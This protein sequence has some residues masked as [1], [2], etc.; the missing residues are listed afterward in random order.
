M[1]IRVFIVDDSAVARLSM[2]RTLR[3]DPDLLLVGEATTGTEAL[4]A[5]PG[6][7]PDIVLMDVMMPEL[8]GLETTA[9]LMQRSARPILIVSDLVGVDS[10]LN[11]RALEAGALDLVRKPTAAEVDDPQRAR[12]WL[13]RLK[14][15]AGVPV[16]TRRSPG[17]R[18]AVP[19]VESRPPQ[20]GELPSL[21]AI[22]ASTGGPPAL[23]EI[24][25]ALG[26]ARPWPM[27]IVQHIAPGFTPGLAHWLAE[28]TGTRVELAAAGQYPLAG[29][30]YVAPDDTHLVFNGLCFETLETPPE[31]GHRPSIDVFLRS[32]AATTAARSSV[33]VLLTGMGEDG[34]RGLASLR[35][36]GAWTMAQDEATSVVYG[37]PK[38][39]VERGAACET[40]AL[41]RIAP[42]LLQ[43][44]PGAAGAVRRDTGQLG[45]ERLTD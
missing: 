43:L 3:H 21:V 20:T 44:T 39:A 38:A 30:A 41:A 33:G 42:R 14:L 28:S 35:A 18:P 19:T 1:T 22:G 34:A 11:F 7:L 10:D 17:L 4:A 13:R 8:N 9:A 12:A 15:L 23:L 32:L 29:R 36:A 37:M 45:S 26:P 24:L 5:I 16:V 27:V 2:R 40:L 31:Q 6:L 25:R